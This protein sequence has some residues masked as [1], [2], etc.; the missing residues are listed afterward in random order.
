MNRFANTKNAVLDEKCKM[1][2]KNPNPD[3]AF[4]VLN[5]C[6]YSANGENLKDGLIFGEYFLSQFPLNNFNLVNELGNL[7][8]TDKNYVKAVELYTWLTNQKLSFE[9]SNMV[10]FNLNFSLKNISGTYTDYDNNYQTQFTNP[11]PY[12]TLSVTSCK[13][14][15]LFEKTIN[16]FLKC[17][18][19]KHLISEWIC[20]DDNSSDEDRSTMKKK[21]PFF[22]FYFKGPDERGHPKSMNIIRKLCKTKYLFHI[23]DDWEFLI[24]DT[25]ISKCI[26]VLRSNPVIKQCLLNK[27]YGELP[28]CLESIIGGEFA[29]TNPS[30]EG[31]GGVRYYIHEQMSNQEY[32]AKYGAR[33]NCAYWPHFSFRPSVVDTDIFSQ[34]NVGEFNE[35]P[36]CSHFEME[37]AVRYVAKG[38]KSAFLEGIYC[39]HIG[40]LT[41]DRSSNS[42]VNA[43]DL[44]NQKQ[45]SPNIPATPPTPSTPVPY[46]CYI[47]NLDRRSDRWE[48][49]KKVAASAELDKVV[50]YQRFSAIDGKR[51]V[52]TR[53]LR[54]IFDPNNYNWTRGVI[55]CA[56]SH[57][58][59][60]SNLVN[61]PD[62][63]GIIVLEDDVELVK[64]FG[65][66]MIGIYKQAEKLRDNWDIIQLGT[67]V[68]AFARSTSTDECK[69]PSLVKKGAQE[70]IKYSYGGT[71]GYMISKKGAIKLL[72]YLNYNGMICAI[73]TM[74]FHASDYIC[75]FFAEPGIVTSECLCTNANADTDIQRD[76]NNKDAS[77][78]IDVNQRIH[79]EI[80]AIGRVNIIGD[81]RDLD[82][83]V[84]NI[85][86]MMGRDVEGY[87]WHQLGMGSVY[88]H[89]KLFPYVKDRLWMDRL[90]NSIGAY[91]VAD[92]IEYSLEP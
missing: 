34:E 59:L 72:E 62:E 78:D 50:N 6:R 87:R 64:N 17:C 23:E 26:H 16:S 30:R 68:R 63:K 2:L 19:D 38:Y 40:R 83:N 88:V 45:F 82:P 77:M 21:Y 15:N 48:K 37:Y 51:L 46:K 66:K 53:Q 84:V 3:T 36:T 92:A 32:F 69:I 57:L 90:K 18:L 56:L 4:D 60:W 10:L 55:G 74:I 43:Y 33:R 81:T 29:V 1:Y 5:C 85:S 20:V 39:K 27:N 73:D 65:P 91:S 47:V 7:Y 52:S 54:R 89:D 9:Y 44:N 86:F 79:E 31:A 12:I 70:S 61:S 24:K 75:N 49:F 14:L 22:T 71:I 28:E 80:Q 11:L 35:S 8:F 42:I 67:F 58:V 25:Y 76:Y 41:S 13:R